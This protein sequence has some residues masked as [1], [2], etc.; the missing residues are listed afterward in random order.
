MGAPQGGTG[1]A[2]SNQWLSVPENGEKELEGRTESLRGAGTEIG[3]Q[4]SWEAQ[5]TKT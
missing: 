4:G 5:I 1:Q 2:G 3:S